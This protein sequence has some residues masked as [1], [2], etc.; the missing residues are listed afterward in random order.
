MKRRKQNRRRKS[1]FASAL[2]VEESSGKTGHP[3][4][5]MANKRRIYAG[6]SVLSTDIR[7]ISVQREL[8]AYRRRDVEVDV[9]LHLRLK[10]PFLLSS[11]LSS[12]FLSSHPASSNCAYTAL[13]HECI[14]PVSRSRRFREIAK[15]EI[16]R[17]CARLTEGKDR[18]IAEYIV[19]Y[20][21]CTLGNSR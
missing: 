7:V 21:L 13:M 12:F 3:V 1:A 19:G 6:N 10:F 4:V 16:L 20:E 18:R 15:G 5:G 11:F 14:S 17:E 8:S 2:D 9:R